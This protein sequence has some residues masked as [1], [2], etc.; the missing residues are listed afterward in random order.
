MA[1]LEFHYVTIWKVGYRFRDR[2]YGRV[3]GYGV[4]NFLATD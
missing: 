2:V 4:V 3:R 1:L